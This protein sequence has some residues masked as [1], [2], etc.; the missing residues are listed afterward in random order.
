MSDSTDS[1]SIV[2]IDW[3]Q[4]E[5]DMWRHVA[6]FLGLHALTLRR[7]CSAFHHRVLTLEA[8]PEATVACRAVVRYLEGLDEKPRVDGGCA[9]LGRR[10]RGEQIQRSLVA[11]SLHNLFAVVDTLD[12]NTRLV[13]SKRRCR[14]LL[15]TW[16][17]DTV[18][19]ERAGN[20]GVC[21]DETLSQDQLVDALRRFHDLGKLQSARRIAFRDMDGAVRWTTTWHEA[22]RQGLVKVLK[23]LHKETYQPL[24]QKTCSGNNALAHAR[25]AKAERLSR[26]GLTQETKKKIEESFDTVIAF[27]L[28]LGLEDKPWHTHDWRQDD[29]EEELMESSDS[30][31]ELTSMAMVDANGDIEFDY[32]SS[33]DMNGAD[34]T[35]GTGSTDSEFEYH[36]QEDLPDADVWDPVPQ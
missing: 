16:R 27:L 17:V 18:L 31:H 6:W 5:D 13:A 29:T 23:F 9:T 25:Q 3:L 19:T 21:T 22:A 14:A 26:V 2:L 34:G 36:W 12:N 15:T 20:I 7:A 33:E 4:L 28:Q 35:D 8:L 11:L 24:H 1:K 32:D 30:E 10:L